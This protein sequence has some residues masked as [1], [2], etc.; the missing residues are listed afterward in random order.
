MN[1]GLRDRDHRPDGCAQAA[2]RRRPVRQGF[3]R[4]LARRLQERPVFSQVAGRKRAVGQLQVAQ[5]L[6]LKLADV[7][8]RH[9]PRRLDT[10]EHEL[11]FGP[12]NSLQPARW[13]AGVRDVPRRRKGQLPAEP[14]Q[15][16]PE[17]GILC[18]NRCS[19]FQPGLIAP[20]RMESDPMRLQ[21]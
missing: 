19:R 20:S 16:D 8:G 2:P 11:E 4:L 1:R 7:R 14:I 3:Q 21:P 13:I 9:P 6:T 10:H 17:G 12:W 5:A 15:D 18:I